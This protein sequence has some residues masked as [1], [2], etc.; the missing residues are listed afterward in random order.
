MIHVTNDL[1]DGVASEVSE[2]LTHYVDGAA[3]IT[4]TPNTVEEVLVNRDMTHLRASFGEHADWVA[5]LIRDSA[6]KDN[7]YLAEAAP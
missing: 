2:Y 5:R 6:G 7:S 1:L 3:T 4:I